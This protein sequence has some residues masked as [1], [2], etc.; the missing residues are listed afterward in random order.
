MFTLLLEGVSGMSWVCPQRS[1]CVSGGNSGFHLGEPRP[2]IFRQ[3]SI[4]DH[5]L[6]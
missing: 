6:F 4:L 3:D 2:T 1:V 5:V